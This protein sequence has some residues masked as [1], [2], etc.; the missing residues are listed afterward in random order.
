MTLLLNADHLWCSLQC[1]P[2]EEIQKLVFKV[3]RYHSLVAYKITLGTLLI[4]HLRQVNGRLVASM[5][6]S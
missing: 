5:Y 1:H 4:L 2:H 3:L 6:R